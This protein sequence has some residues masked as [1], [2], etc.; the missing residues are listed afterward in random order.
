MKPWRSRCVLINRLQSAQYVLREGLQDAR[1]NVKNDL[2]KVI[3]GPR[4][5]GKSVFAIQMLAVVTLMF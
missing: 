2:I 1:K 4:G 5:A 3:V